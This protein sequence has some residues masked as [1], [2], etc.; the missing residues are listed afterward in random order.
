MKDKRIKVLMVLGSLQ[1]GGAEVLCLTILQNI[2]RAKYQIDFAVTKLTGTA[3]EKEA[4]KLGANIHLVPKFKGYNIF[5]FK[6]AW[7]KLLRDNFY[8]I[9]HGHASG[10]M[11]IYLK[12]AKEMGCKT[13]AHS[14][15][16]LSSGNAFVQCVKKALALKVPKRSDYMV[17]CSEI[18][19]IKLFGK[20][21]NKNSN[22]LFIP[23]GIDSLKFRFNQEIRN[24]LR[25]ELGINESEFLFGNV[26]RL[27]EQKNQSFLLDIFSKIR[28]KQSESYLLLCG[29]GPLKDA[30]I[31][32][33]KSLGVLDYVKFIGNVSNVNEY[34]SAMDLFL[35]P[36]L[37]EGLP[38]TMVEAQAAGLGVVCSDTIT[39]EVKITD[40]VKYLSF[41]ETPICWA[42]EIINLVKQT[43]NRYDDNELVNRSQF[44]IE[45][46]VHS[47]VFVYERVLKGK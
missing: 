45:T 18:A 30:L 12:I 46:L 8:D 41:K 10:A 39:R 26:G 27:T 15:A 25:Q 29:E 35:L 33:A 20:D 22:Y 1:F 17:A 5:S 42:D 6:K 14:H 21:F 43:R 23:N 44:N 31:K 34:M 37:F 3:I 40:G 16:S 7:R 47:I 24:R 9:V 38:V 2:D 11:S 28:E 4:I 19:A 32:K 36:S 13:V